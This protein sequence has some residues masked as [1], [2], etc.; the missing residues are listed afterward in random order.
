MR[1]VYMTTENQVRLFSRRYCTVSTPLNLHVQSVHQYAT[2]RT[3]YV[4]RC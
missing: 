4:Q 2:E 1:A 3:C